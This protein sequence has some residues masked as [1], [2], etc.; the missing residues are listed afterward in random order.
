MIRDLIGVLLVSSGAA[1]LMVAV[2]GTVVMR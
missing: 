1:A 2:V